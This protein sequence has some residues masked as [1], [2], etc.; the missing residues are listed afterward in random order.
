MTNKRRLAKLIVLALLTQLLTAFFPVVSE[1]YIV[2]AGYGDMFSDDEY[3]VQRLNYAFDMYG[4]GDYFSKN[5][6]ACTCHGH[7]NCVA[8]GS[9]CN[10]LR[11]VVI[12]G[13]K[14]DLRAVQCMGYAMY[15]QQV[16]FGCNEFSNSSKFKN[17][18][19]PGK[20]SKDGV[21]K[22]FVENAEL[23]HPGT[24]IR[25]RS[26]EH[27]IVLM[28]VDYDKGTITYI[29]NNWVGKCK[30]SNFTTLTWSEFASKFKSINYAKVY[31]NYYSIFDG[32]PDSDKVAELKK[33]LPTSTPKAKA[34]KTPTPT[35]SP[36]PASYTIGVYEVV[37]EKNTNL[38]LR[39]DTSTSSEIVSKMASGTQIE[40]LDFVY[41]EN[42]HHWG[43]VPNDEGSGWVAMEFL[44]LVATIT[45]TPTNTPVPAD[46]PPGQYQVKVNNKLNVRQSYSTNSDII[47]TFAND[48]IV[49][50]IEFV[51]GYTGT[52]WGSVTLDDMTKGWVAM[53][54]MHPVV[55]FTPTPTPPAPKLKDINSLEVTIYDAPLI[56]PTNKVNPTM[57]PTPVPTQAE[58]S[59]VPDV[60]TEPVLEMPMEN[61]K[62]TFLQN[63]TGQGDI[64]YINENK[65]LLLTA[66]ISIGLETVLYKRIRKLN[67]RKWKSR[68]GRKKTR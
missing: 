17:I 11:Y 14:C 15:I 16:L 39:A 32:A 47:G 18:S 29:D 57:S 51:K 65:W 42:G 66:I 55:T 2:Y 7:G 50:I 41:N 60:T 64:K 49:D 19:G 20:V 63:I 23:L 45:P 68:R 27:S 37:T 35:I 52:D 6:K 34:T 13:E 59:P 3:I 25:V 26:S 44:S 48:T 62:A 30:I 1:E 5:G 38:N 12:D 56:K 24:H 9:N 58:V 53:S 21:K 28:A 31:K 54:Y 22:W 67:S 43:L 33:N 8:S 4:P 40:I 46:Y 10:C 61:D 36:K